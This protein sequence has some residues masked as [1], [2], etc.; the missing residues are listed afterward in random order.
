[1]TL[2]VLTQAAL[3]VHIARHDG[4]VGGFHKIGNP[5][6]HVLDDIDAGGVVDAIGHFVRILAGHDRSA[7]RTAD[8]KAGVGVFEPH[9]S[10]ARRSI[11]GV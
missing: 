7:G 10:R 5:L 3:S 8:W 6:P 4:I 11:C 9:P 2:F 1:M